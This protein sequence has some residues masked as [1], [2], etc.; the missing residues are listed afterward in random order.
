MFI[1]YIYLP[2]Y[3]LLT[4]FVDAIPGADLGLAVI[5]VTLAVRL[6]FLPVSLSAAKT[7]EAMKEIQPKLKEIREKHKTDPQVQ[8]RAMM[9]LYK[10]HKVRPLSSLLLMLIQIPVLFGLFFVT[11]DVALDG[12]DPALLYSF[13]PAP[14]TVAVFFLGFFSVATSSIVLAAF[15]GVTQYFYARL[16]VP[17]PPKKSSSEAS[18]QDEFGRAMALQMRY[19]FPLL[20]AFVGLASGAVALYLAAGN[21]FMLGQHYFVKRSMAKAA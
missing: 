4:F 13:I 19:M 21:L 8:A 5:A 12:I 7:Q 17:V 6:I 2:I 1:D 16:A 18:M 11:K 15:A 10:E 20:I 3:N 9:A 14:E